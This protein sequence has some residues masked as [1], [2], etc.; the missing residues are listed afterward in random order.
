MQIKSIITDK[1]VNKRAQKHVG[2]QH[3]STRSTR[4]RKHVKHM[5]TQTRQARDLPDS[6]RTMYEFFL[7]V[8]CCSKDLKSLEKELTMPLFK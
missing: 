4:A 2:M 1:N 7:K 8:I 6:T 3:V 5:S